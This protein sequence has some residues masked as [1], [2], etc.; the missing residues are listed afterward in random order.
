ML[1][2]FVNVLL[3]T[4]SLMNLLVQ[5]C[6]DL[7]KNYG[8]DIRAGLMAFFHKVAIETLSFCF[9]DLSR[10]NKSEV[11]HTTKNRKTEKDYTITR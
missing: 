7:P 10:N 5:T 2:I 1:L 4:P 9:L 11:P 6:N 3:I 8:R